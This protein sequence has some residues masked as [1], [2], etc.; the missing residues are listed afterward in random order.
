MRFPA[1]S[2]TWVAV[3][4]CLWA[5]AEPVHA[6]T[7]IYRTDSQL[8]A[9]SER[10]VHGRV[11]DQRTT[12]VGPQGRI[13]TVTTLRVIEDLT[14]IAG[15]TVEVWELGGRVGDEFLHV[16]GAVEYRPGEEVLVCLERGPFGLRSVAMGLSKFEVLRESNGDRL[17]QRSLQDTVVVGG[18][19]AREPTLSEMR[20][21]AVRAT[22]RQPRLGP[23]QQVGEELAAISGR[24]TK[25]GGEPGWRWV[26]ADSS[27]PVTWY[28]NASAPNPLLTG[29]AVS[30]TQTSLAAWTN[31][32][33]ASIILQ[34][35]GTTIQSSATGPWSGLP[36]GSAVI[37]F[38]DPNNEIS[39]STLAIGGGS[40]FG[41]TGGTVN[42]TTFNGFARGYVIFQN[43]ANLSTSFRQSLNF[44]RVLTHEIGH[45]IGLGHTQ[46][47]GTIPN[48]TSN[49]MYPSCCSGSTPVPPALGPDDLDGLNFIYPAGSSVCTYS[50]NP[51]SASATAAGGGGSVSV[52][53]QPGCGWTA[54]TNSGFLSIASGSPGS[55]PGSVSYNVAAS[56]LTSP[57]SGT[58]TIAGRTF[59]V[60]QA[61]APC[62]YA[63]TPASASMAA[64]GGNGTVNIGTQS[65]CP[66]NAASNDGFLS[67]TS[68]ASGTGS[69][70]VSYNV[71][72]NGM[73][74]RTGTLT[75]ASQ[76]VTVNQL[77]SGPLATLDKQSL[78]YGATLSGSV[79]TAQTTAQTIRLTQSAGAAL[80][81]T[82]TTNQPWLA[83]SPASGTGA[84][85]LS[86]T[87]SPAGLAT[88]GTGTGSVTLT[89][90]N[91]GN[92]VPPVAV[93][94]SLMPTGTSA[95]PFGVVDTPVNN[96]GGVVG[97][98]PVTGWALDDVE[99]SN[100]F[101]CRSPMAGE[102]P[103]ADGR[104]GGASQVFLGEAVFIDGA[105]PDVRAA[106]P[107]YPRETRG[108]WGFMVLTNMLPG[109]GNGTYTLVLH[110]RDRESHSAVL[111]SRTFTCSNALSTK[112]F[113]AIDTPTQGG[114]ASGASYVNF[115]WA[116]TPSPKT[117]PA[118]GSTITVFVDGLPMGHPTYNNYRGDIAALFPGLNNTNGAI[119]FRVLDTTALAN[120]LHTIAWTVTDDQGVTEGIGSRY[121]IVSNGVA[122]STAEDLL[123]IPDT[124]EIDALPVD[125]SPVLGRRGWN[126]ESPWRAHEP[127]RAGLIVVRA[128]EVGLVEVRLDAGTGADTRYEGY[129]RTSATLGPLPV[130]ARLDA[131]AGVFV[132]QPGVGFVGTYDFVFVRRDGGYPV[133]RR[134]VR[135]VLQTKGSGFVGPQVVIDTPAWQ[136]DVAQPFVL[137]G[138]AADL[139]ALEGTGIGAVHA[140]AYPL[141]GGPP[142]FLGAAAAGHARP[143]VAAV[144][145]DRFRDSGYGMLVLG[146]TPGH[147]DVAVFAWSEFVADFV[148]ATVVRV[149]VR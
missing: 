56:S 140:W 26:Q 139:Q 107:S 76:T 32:A 145:G 81:W 134:E 122:S 79:V 5:V 148:P 118:D 137:A 85:D 112:P 16:G 65:G 49:I 131:T 141:S 136:A 55:G 14:G 90:A 130:G 138:W 78:Q 99:V 121:F 63:V 115:G 109:Q 1:R 70:T 143:D 77:G 30:E 18:V 62:T 46:T 72:G 114:V 132:W 71:S 11:V 89:F 24:F 69:T 84:A 44:T 8:V 108:G 35:G 73:N 133:S 29:D 127:G 82:A 68:A 106:F 36:G 40:G 86:V 52:S 105:R 2:I 144:H 95:N 60:N 47:N 102:S 53:T 28:M 113:G 57:R 88:P 97:A 98:I 38:E 20:T 4:G 66:W 45:A 27:T 15:D 3:L 142:V 7:V 103:A 59:T 111:G 10:V 116:L 22:G 80:T 128:E 147:Y 117:I 129:L 51:T 91:A 50:I 87:V 54:V 25:L 125:R 17:L 21:L 119:G 75:I 31:P 34:Y 124:H 23:P 67:I 101:V 120:G 74:A 92:F 93:T 64:A 104:C 43:A 110:A 96:I 9:L 149:T 83:V 94:L 6:S 19:V 41:G 58:L 126:L 13:Y 61:A 135:V 123:G 33:S 146:L 12:R 100:V 48:A 39:G 37:T 42:G